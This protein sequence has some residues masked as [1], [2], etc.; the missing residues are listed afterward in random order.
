M[1]LDEPQRIAHGGLM[2]AFDDRRQ[3]RI[4]DRP[5]GGH[6]LHGENVKS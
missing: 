4:G 5:Q 2:R 6:R 1:L 3:G